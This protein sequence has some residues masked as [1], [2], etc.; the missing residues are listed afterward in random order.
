MKMAQTNFLGNDY[1]ES[2]EFLASKYMHSTCVT[3]EL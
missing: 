1:V 2:I 3:I